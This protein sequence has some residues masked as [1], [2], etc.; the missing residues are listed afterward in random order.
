MRSASWWD[1]TQ[2]IVVIPCRRFG[3]TYRSHLHGS[4][5]SWVRICYY[6][7]RNNSHEVRVYD[8]NLAELTSI[9]L[10]NPKQSKHFI[11]YSTG[12]L[13]AS[14][15]IFYF[16]KYRCNNIALPF[17]PSYKISCYQ[18]PV[19]LTK[20]PQPCANPVASCPTS[21]NQSPRSGATVGLRDVYFVLS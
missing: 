15:F 11:R 16:Y 10:L 9:H 14:M 18:N 13:N 7:L 17:H 1:I 2:R 12:Q 4:R 20:F 19:T 8:M 6:A 21:L 3:T 5:N